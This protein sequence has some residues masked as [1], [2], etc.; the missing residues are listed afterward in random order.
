MKFTWTL[1]PLGKTID[2]GFREKIVI[3]DS[4]LEEDVDVN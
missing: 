1:Q 4:V 3:L 2:Y